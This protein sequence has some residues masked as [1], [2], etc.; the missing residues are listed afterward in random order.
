MEDTTDNDSDFSANEKNVPTLAKMKIRDD[1]E[2][3]IV[4]VKLP[5]QLSKHDGVWRKSECKSII[6][7][8]LFNL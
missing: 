7:N 1:D 4:T 5:I 6:I 3:I 8:T 2:V